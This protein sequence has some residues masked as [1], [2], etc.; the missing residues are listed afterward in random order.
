MK[1]ILFVCTGNTCRSSMAE[2]LFG[3]MV[4]K[5]E[6]K[7]NIKVISAGTGAM[8]GEKASP[9]AIK[10]MEEYG[11][12]LCKHKAT[13]L[14]KELVKGADIVLTMTA[15]HKN[16][17]LSICPEAAGKVF[18]LREYVATGKNTD[19]ILDEMNDVYKEIE[20]KK[21]EFLMKNAKRLNELKNKR[22]DLLRELKLID[23]E[24]AAIEEEFRHEIQDFERTLQQLKDSM[25]QPDIIDPFGQPLEVY[26]RTAKE[27]EDILTQLV[28]KLKAED[29]FNS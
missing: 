6:G 24:V 7:P 2:A 25:P 22:D 8:K 21:Q 14:T 1:T 29:Y 5:L 15:N 10:I 28:K 12:S 4:E 20:L 18:T 19:D 3:S 16:T 27:I 17:V 9:Q 13:P 11:I 23:K 26:R